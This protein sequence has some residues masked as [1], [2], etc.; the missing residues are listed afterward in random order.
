[1]AIA[2]PSMTVETPCDKNDK[3]FKRMSK[4]DRSSKPVKNDILKESDHASPAFNHEGRSKYFS[5]PRQDESK[6]FKV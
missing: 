6:T 2:A 1:M 5:R 4:N 3:S